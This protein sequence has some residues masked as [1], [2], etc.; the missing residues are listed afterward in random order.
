MRRITIEDSLIKKETRDFLKHLDKI[1][2]FPNDIKMGD[3]VGC[4]VWNN[5]YYKILV[6]ID[7]ENF[8]FCN[9]VTFVNIM[10]T[11]KRSPW[12]NEELNEKYKAKEANYDKSLTFMDELREL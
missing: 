9:H 5:K 11:N 6:P 8:V 10:R 4:S 2:K 1:Q 7:W 3:F 12:R